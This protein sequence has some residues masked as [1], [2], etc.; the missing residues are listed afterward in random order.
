MKTI[1]KRRLGLVFLS[2][3]LLEAANHPVFGNVTAAIVDPINVAAAANGGTASAST[4]ADNY[5]PDAVIDGDRKGLNLTSGGAWRD[6]TPG[7]FPDWVQVN[8]VDV[9]SIDEISVVT[10]QDQWWNP[11]EPTE[12]TAFFNNG[13]TSFE[14]QYWNGSSWVTIP[15]LVET[16]NSK[17]WRRFDFPRIDTDRIRVLIKAA[18]SSVSTVV[19]VEAIGVPAT[20]PDPNPTPTPT[21]VPESVKAVLAGLG[22]FFD[23]DNNVGFGTTEPVFNDDGT[24]GAF[25]GKFVAIDGHLTGAAAY[26]GL[27]GTVPNPSDRVGALNFYNWAMGGVD[28]RTASIFSFNGP[29]LGTGTLEFATAPNFIGPVRRVQIA[30]TGEMGI[31]HLANKGTQLTVMGQSTAANTHALA[32]LDGADRLT[33][34]V[35]DDGQLV[36][37]RPGQGIVLRSP[38][39]LVCRKLVIDDG[40]ELVVQ[41]MPSCP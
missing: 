9:M 38:N 31:N 27:G 37:G 6:A 26:L 22:I 18:K 12:T 10:Q 15:G 2:L 29:T 7:V 25:V 3:L 40:G 11:I 35:Q 34:T 4:T 17:V 20:A 19:E 21:P 14:V 30:A 1:F 33:F 39:G 41:S 23:Q 28:H 32:V 5:T 36:V 8:F 16:N 13:I 24:T